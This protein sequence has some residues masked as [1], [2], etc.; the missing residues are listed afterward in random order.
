VAE[1]L[2]AVHDPLRTVLAAG[3]VGPPLEVARAIARA[4]V[5][6]HAPVEPPAWLRPEQRAVLPPLCGALDHFGGA[7]LA[8][9]PGSGKTWVALAAVA[10]L[11]VPAVAIVPA[12]LRAQWRETAARAGVAVGLLSHEAV[13]RGR[14][15]EEDAALVIIDESHRFRTPAARRYQAL[16]PWLVGRRA[17]LLSATPVVNHLTDLAHQLLLAVPD[18]ALAARGVPSL[19]GLLAAGRGHPALGELVLA[20]PRP[21]GFPAAVHRALSVSSTPVERALLAELG[22]LRLSRDPG[23]AAL[24]RG[25]LLRAFASSPRA[26]AGALARYL[27][28]LVQAR[29]ARRAGRRVGRDLVRRWC[30]A[31]LDQYT[32]WAVL[33]EEETDGSGGAAICT[34]DHDRVARLLARAR[35]LA[36]APDARV[37]ALIRLLD[38]GRPTIVFTTSR[39]TL[40]YLREQL[41]ALRP[42]WLSGAAAGIGAVQLPR[43]AVLGWFGPSPRELPP[44]LAPPSVLLATDV[45]A[46]G[47]DL[48]RAARVVHYDLPWTSVRLDQR[49]GRARRLG[50]VARSVDVVRLPAFPELEAA[51]TLLERI[52]RKRG[53]AGIVGL[54]EESPWLHRWRLELV[55]PVARGAWTE[56][57]ATMP[58]DEAG[59]L[60]GLGYSDAGSVSSPEEMLFGELLWIPHEGALTMD[61]ARTVP[62]LM[63]ALHSHATPV[64]LHAPEPEPPWPIIRASVRARLQEAT[65]SS[66]APEPR[67]EQRRLVRRL[68]ALAR[69]A[70]RRRD[71]TELARLDRGLTRLSSGLTAGE[72]LLV[73]E[74]AAAPDAALLTLAERLGPARRTGPACLVPRLTGIVRVTSFPACPATAPCSSTSTAR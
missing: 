40:A 68:Q 35:R 73:M 29:S 19:L 16:A 39:D 53:L 11:G 34:S 63:R 2:R 8:D 31:A 14:L 46:E 20:R 62:I 72:A 5:P 38:D 51:L 24:I 3:P 56:G 49:E 4:L 12:A 48:Q 64:V 1:S 32:L 60:V 15:P 54:S 61:P 26:L 58:G 70:A 28:L 7:L 33:P 25:L 9:P 42:A 44:P 22:R 69:A 52:G 57:I 41:A 67:L 6:H 27:A 18:D 30:G 71:G 50:G 66:L 37:A 74:A 23:V 13:S 65:G 59:W 36:D 21:P 43:R 17:L 47:L 10:T 45:A 55:A